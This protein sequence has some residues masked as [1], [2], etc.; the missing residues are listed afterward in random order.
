[1]DECRDT[2]RAT[3]ATQINLSETWYADSAA[4][5]LLSVQLGLVQCSFFII[6]LTCTNLLYRI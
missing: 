2:L 1:M 6:V 3:L 4:L 5:C